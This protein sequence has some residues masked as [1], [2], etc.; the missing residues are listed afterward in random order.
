MELFPASFY[1]S[2]EFFSLGEESVGSLLIGF[3]GR[4]RTRGRTTM[5]SCS[6][7]L[8]LLD[9]ILTELIRPL[10]LS[11]GKDTFLCLGLEL[12]HKNVWFLSC[13]SIL[14]IISLISK[15]GKKDLYG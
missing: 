5:K 1:G 10:F 11:I 15:R 7:E 2:K 4:S 9:A 6:E 12:S 14:S 3:K 8:G 13:F